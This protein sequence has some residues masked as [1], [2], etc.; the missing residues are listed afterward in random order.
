MVQ[1]SIQ[2]CGQIWS[3]L[4]VGGNVKLNETTVMLKFKI[5]ELKYPKLHKYCST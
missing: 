3:I 5:R 1:K 4:A 2:T